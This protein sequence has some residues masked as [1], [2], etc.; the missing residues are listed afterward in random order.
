M[1]SIEIEHLDQLIREWR[2]LKYCRC[3]TCG[4]IETENNHF[5]VGHFIKRGDL[6]TRWNFNNIRAQCIKCNR[7][8]A[9]REH[10]FKRKL[11]LDGVNVEK[12]KRLAKESARIDIEVFE[13]MVVLIREEIEKMG[14][15]ASFGANIAEKMKGKAHP[16]RALELLGIEEDEDDF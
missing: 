16:Y 6:A 13:S 10:E 11:E 15:R 7:L 12:L 3:F 4:K 5:D 14:G 1:R 2:R 8:E 9:G